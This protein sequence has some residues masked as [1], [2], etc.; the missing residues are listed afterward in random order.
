MLRRPGESLEEGIAPLWKTRMRW[1]IKGLP[2]S[3]PT[4]AKVMVYFW[5]ASTGAMWRER[6]PKGNKSC[7]VAARVDSSALKGATDCAN[8]FCGASISWGFMGCDRGGRAVVVIVPERRLE[9]TSLSQWAGYP[10]E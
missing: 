3:D 10:M 8:A 5:R 2:F 7:H 9:M 1:C 6:M 4:F